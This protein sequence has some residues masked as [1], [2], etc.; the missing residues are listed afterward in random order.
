VRD[1]G[2]VT[3][4][5][6]GERSRK[7]TG[8]PP[9]LAPSIRRLPQGEDESGRRRRVVADWALGERVFGGAAKDG[10]RPVGLARADCRDSLTRS[11]ASAKSGS[12]C[13][14][15]AKAGTSKW[16]RPLYRLQAWREDAIYGKL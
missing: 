5:A 6:H 9:A 3:C 14:C 4:R 12:G 8:I 13:C 15:A 1:R 2:H 7:P 16:G 11:R 10:V